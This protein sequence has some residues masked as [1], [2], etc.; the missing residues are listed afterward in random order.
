[1]QVARFRGE[2]CID[3][4]NQAEYHGHSPQVLDEV[5]AFLSKHAYRTAEFTGKAK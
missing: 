2:Q 4:F 3:F 5:L 1:M